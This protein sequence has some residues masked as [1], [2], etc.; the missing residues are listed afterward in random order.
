[1]VVVRV[2]PLLIPQLLAA[3]L[4][5]TSQQSFGSRAPSTVRLVRRLCFVL[6]R[7]PVVWAGEMPRF[8]TPTSPGTR[9]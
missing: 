2:P 5:G 4:I 7:R 8:M 1:M 6:L 9:T 3:L